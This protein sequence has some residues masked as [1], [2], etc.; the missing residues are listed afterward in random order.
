MRV[1]TDEHLNGGAITI[2]SPDKKINNV[3]RCFTPELPETV[4]TDFSV[5]ASSVVSRLFAAD[6]LLLGVCRRN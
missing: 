3:I 4:H 6:E 1:N 5:S 2:L